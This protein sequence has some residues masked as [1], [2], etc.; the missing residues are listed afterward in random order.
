MK[1]I[2]FLLVL[3]FT[4]SIVLTSCREKSTVEKVADDVEDAVD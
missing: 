3:T 1:K 2:V 4:T